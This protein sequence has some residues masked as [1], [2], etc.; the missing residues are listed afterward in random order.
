M[1]YCYLLLT[2]LA[3]SGISASAK[4]GYRV[5]IKLNDKRDSMVYL[6]YYFGK[7]LP[8]IFKTDSARLDKNGVAVFQKKE[9]ITGGM[10][11]VLPEDKKSYFEILLNNGDDLSVTAT[12]TELP[13]SVKFKN[14][15]LNEDFINYQKYLKTVGERQQQWQKDLANAKTAA[16]TAA[17]RAKSRSLN[18][19][20]LAYRK[21]YIRENPGNLLSSIFNAVELPNVPEGTHYLPDGKVD[22][23]YGYR[24]YKTHFW[25][26]FN[27]NDDR[28]IHTPLLEMRLTEYFNKVLYQHE[29]TV[30]QYA[31]SILARA[32]GS[33]NLF[34][35]TLN[36]L[37]TNAQ[38]SK[39]M[40]MDKVFV[41]LVRNYYMKGAA[42]WLS[43][44]E[45]QKYIKRAEDIEPNLMNS[46]APQ[47]RSVDVL[48]Q[49]KSLYDFKA[50]YTLLIF[51]SPDCGHCMQEIPKLDSVY[52]AV[53][54]QK[55]VRMYGFN[56]DTEELKWRE[57]IKKE[58]LDDWQHVWDPKRKSRYWDLYD[59]QSTP[60][61]YLLDE[62]KIIAG[63][64]LDH[65]TIE[66]ALEIFE[67]KQKGQIK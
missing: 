3:C 26:G 59:V 43:D 61:I 14:S 56:T 13:E 9:K 21:K 41:H 35:F 30:I 18:D 60:S 64:K 65:T 49:P 2:M 53:L 23:L 47:L 25:D 10:Y 34:K 51:Y 63:K 57:F 27:F 50:K 29:D 37:S 22:S 66:R 15:P 4:D 6:A 39:I 20:V 31:D 11:M 58:K 17:L 36:W 32:R 19:E 16:D 48:G 7:S 40:G 1:K 33:E 52:R 8:T 24:Y 54:K 42:N 28:L 55:G 67:M 5:Q 45:L 44:E 12:M 62:N 46:P 38:T